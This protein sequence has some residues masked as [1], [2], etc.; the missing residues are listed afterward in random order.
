MNLLVIG[1]SVF[2]V[3]ED[4]GKIKYSAGGIFYTVSAL[5]KIN[6]AN[7]EIFL[8]SCFDEETYHHF[9]DEFSKVNNSLLNKIEKIPRV[10]LKLSAG[11]ER[12]EI[13]ENLGQPLNLKIS[14]YSKFDG[15]MI[16]MITGFD[17]TLQQLQRI[18]EKCDGI[19]FMDIHTL[20]RGVDKD[21]SRNFRLIP[22]F[23]SWA[24]CIDVIQVNQNEIYTLFPLISEQEIAKKVIDTGVKILCVTKGELGAKIYYVNDKEMSSFYISAKKIKDPVSVGCGDIFGSAFFYNYI[25]NHDARFSLKQAVKNAELFVAGLL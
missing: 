8:C 10:K 1:H 11:N 21:Q 20:S 19:I 14:D 5:N 13:Y 15:I 25:R 18:R 17:I 9:K 2:D 12:E 16:N 24:E 22:D 3:I 7:D 6:L 23:K 4:A